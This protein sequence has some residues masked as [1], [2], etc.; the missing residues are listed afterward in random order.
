MTTTVAFWLVCVTA[1]AVSRPPLAAPTSPSVDPERDVVLVSGKDCPRY[2]GWYAMTRDA[3]RQDETNRIAEQ[4]QCRLTVAEAQGAQFLAE[5][6]R[7]QAVET[8]E[9]NAWWSRWG[10]PGI[11]LG[12]IFGAIGGV[13]AGVAIGGK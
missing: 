2:G 9:H 3:V 12:L 10:P 11:A 13:A 5:R 4:T 1:C 6:Q 8:A 7:D